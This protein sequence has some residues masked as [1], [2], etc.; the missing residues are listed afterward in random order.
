M[1]FIVTDGG[2][3]YLVNHGG[4][5]IAEQN[6]RYLSDIQIYSTRQEAEDKVMDLYNNPVFVI[7]R[8]AFTTQTLPYGLK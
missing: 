5:W 2:S 3:S 4:T 8:N 7:D 1:W 6:I